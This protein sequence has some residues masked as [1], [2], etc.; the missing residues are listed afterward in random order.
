MRRVL[1]AVTPSEAR[2]FV[3]L[4][5]GLFGLALLGE[6]LR[7]GRLWRWMGLAAATLLAVALVPWIYGMAGGDEDPLLVVGTPAVGLRTEPRQALSP[8]AQ[9]DPGDEVERIDELPGWVR[10]ETTDGTRG[11][12][13]EP[14]VFAL[15][16]SQRDPNVPPIRTAG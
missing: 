9:L 8:I 16:P 15:D 5:A 3:W 10:V 7:G 1:E 11:W 13:P 2:R 4:A 12:V 14:T 6:A